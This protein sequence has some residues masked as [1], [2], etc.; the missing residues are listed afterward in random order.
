MQKKKWVLIFSLLFSMNLCM[1]KTVMN[2]AK[3]KDP[4]TPFIGVWHVVSHDLRE[5]EIPPEN[6]EAQMTQEKEFAGLPIGQIVRFDR[7]ETQVMPGT[8]DPNT[9]R[10]AGPIGLVLEISLLPPF[11]EKLCTRPYWG[12]ACK[13]PKKPL[14]SFAMITEIT[15]WT[16]SAS[17]KNKLTWGDIKKEQYHFNHLGKEYNFEARIAKNGDILLD[18]VLDGKTKGGGNAGLAGVRLKKIGN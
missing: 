3:F 8:I 14:S 4:A 17:T 9:M 13:T 1:A 18:I 12:E 2:N 16:K 5:F 6:I 10:S 15:D 7:G 11:V